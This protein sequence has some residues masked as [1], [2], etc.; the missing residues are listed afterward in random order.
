MKNQDILIVSTI[1]E[2]NSY[3][4]IEALINNLIV[5]APNISGFIDTIYNKN[6][7][8]ELRGLKTINN[9]NDSLEDALKDLHR[10]NYNSEFIQSLIESDNQKIK[11]SILKKLIS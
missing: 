10:A 7:L 5:V 3:L 4:V 8:Y 1:R 6:H 9:M 2:G 11:K